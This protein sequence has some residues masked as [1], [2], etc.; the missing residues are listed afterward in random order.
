MS[1]LVSIRVPS[2]SNMI[3]FVI[4]FVSFSLVPCNGTMCG[5]LCINKMKQNLLKHKAMNTNINLSNLSS[6]FSSLG[7]AMG[8]LLGLLGSCGIMLFVSLTAA[9]KAVIV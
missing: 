2:R 8:L 4:F 6:M 9:M 3:S 7:T 1:F 5:Y